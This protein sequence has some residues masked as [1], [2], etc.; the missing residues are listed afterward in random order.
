MNLNQLKTIAN[1]VFANFTLER[2]DKRYDLLTSIIQDGDAL[3]DEIIDA[4]SKRKE[5]RLCIELFMQEEVDDPTAT[6][7]LILEAMG[8]NINKLQKQTVGGE[9]AEDLLEK[10]VGA[11]KATG[12]VTKKGLNSFAEWL[13]EKTK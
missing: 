3:D 12:R 1:S 10:T 9:L 13:A 5:V 11:T 6:A 4:T 8:Y 2:L 7:G